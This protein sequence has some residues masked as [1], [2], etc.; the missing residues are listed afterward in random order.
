MM[1]E[2]MDD[3]FK[4]KFEARELPFDANHWAMAEQLLNERQQRKLALWW[5]WL[6]CAITALGIVLILMAPSWA[7]T[8]AGKVS[9]SG[10]SAPNADLPRSADPPSATTQAFPA[11]NEPTISGP[12]GKEKASTQT[13]NPEGSRI[14][15]P[16][17]AEPKPA[18]TGV[19]RL[20]V[21]P[22]PVAEASARDENAVALDSETVLPSGLTLQ[23][24]L[25]TAQNLPV[26]LMVLEQLPTRHITVNDQSE[27]EVKWPETCWPERR[28]WRVWT[29]LGGTFTPGNTQG[30]ALLG[31]R[32]Q[33]PG[34]DGWGIAVEGLYRSR[35]VNALP[36][37][38]ALQ[39]NYSFGVEEEAYE[40]QA[41]ALHLV[42]LGLELTYTKGQHQLQAGAGGSYLLGSRGRLNRSAKAED[43]LEYQPATPLSEGWISTEGLSALIGRAYLGY[44]YRVLDD[45]GISARAQYNLTAISAAGSS[46]VTQTPSPFSFEVTVNYAIW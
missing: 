13:V 24:G 17:A 35:P 36:T 10:P 37:Q 31:W 34:R 46:L 23:S 15:P 27:A 28:R 7:A 6:G 16:V 19:E 12:T 5:W 26:G 9:N 30:G 8:V 33:Y 20:P 3:F 1:M 32:V 44:T 45:L 40:M 39:R 21:A 18:K 14:G 4:K 2:P 42:D 41:T 11:G 38:A 29:V 43:E 25:D 22:V